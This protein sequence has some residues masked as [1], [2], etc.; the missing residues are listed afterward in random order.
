MAT[1]IRLT[2][3]GRAKRPFYRLVVMDSR[4]RRDGAFIEKLG[5]YNPIPEFF[6][7]DVDVDNTLAWLEKGATMSDTARS[8]LRQ[9][10]ILYH[11]HLKKQ[12]VDDAEIATKVEEFRGRHEGRLESQKEKAAQAKANAKA[13][14]EAGLKKKAED[15]AKAEQE[16]KEAEVAAAAAAAAEAASEEAAEA[17]AEDASTEETKPEGEES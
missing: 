8:L 5:T 1:T 7:V 17:P 13:E 16:A 10:G 11:W 2:R 9:Q 4:T 14:Y 6:E 15:A 12:G 3:A